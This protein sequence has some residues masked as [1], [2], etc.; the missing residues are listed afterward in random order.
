M[1]LK[2]QG[3]KFHQVLIIFKIFLVGFGAFMSWWQ[4]TGL[5]DHNTLFL[6]PLS[7]LNA[8]VFVV[9]YSIKVQTR[10]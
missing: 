4:M 10:F 9:G 6:N 7:S 1:P 5:K 8:I 3:T 2:H